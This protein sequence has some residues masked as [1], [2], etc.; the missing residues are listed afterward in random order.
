MAFFNDTAEK[1]VFDGKNQ[2]VIYRLTLPILTLKMYMH[3]K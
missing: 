2:I 1:R 3:T